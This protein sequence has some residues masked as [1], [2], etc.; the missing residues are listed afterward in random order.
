MALVLDELASR[1]MWSRQLVNYRTGQ[2]VV[3]G[4]DWG[5]A[6]QWIIANYGPQV[7]SSYCSCKTR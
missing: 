7:H 2:V 1:R 3:M 5:I 6:A 4:A